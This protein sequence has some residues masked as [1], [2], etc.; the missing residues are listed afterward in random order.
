M[1]FKSK[2]PPLRA[3]PRWHGI[4]GPISMDLP[5]EA[6]LILTNKLKEALKPCGVFEDSIELQHREKVVKQLESLYK[7]WLTETSAQMDLPESVIEN[8]GGKIYPFGSYRLGVHSKGADIDALCIGP[9]FL[10][11]KVFFTSFFDKLKAQKEVKNI[12]TIK[13]AY[14]PV[15]KMTYN[16]IEIDLLFAR[17]PRKSI[18][19][20]LNLLNNQWLNGLDIHC[21]RSL[22][23]YRVSE[24][25]LKSVPKVGNFRLALRA[26][27]LWAKRRNIYSNAMG[28]LGGVSWAI[29]VARICQCYPNATSS[30]LVNKFFK[31]YN[32]WEW[33]IPIL[34]RRIEDC[35]YSLPV[36]APFAKA[37]HL[38]PIIT[39]AYPA[40]NTTF[41]VSPSSVAIITE[42]IKRGYA[43]TEDIQQR[44]ADWSNLFEPS[45][46]FDQY[47]HYLLLEATSTTEEQHLE[48]VGLVESKMRL[49]VGNLEKNK[50]VSL[51]HIGLQ[52]FPGSNNGNTK[53]GRSTKWLIG[54]EYKGSESLNVDLNPAFQSFRDTLY[55]C[56]LYQEGMTISA[57]Y[58]AGSNSETPNGDGEPTRVCT[59][60]PRPTVSHQVSATAPA[61][62]TAPVSAGRPAIKR[63]GWSD[64]K[65][66]AKRVKADK[67]SVSVANGSTASTPSKPASNSMSPWTGKRP[68]APQLATS[69]LK[70]KS[71]EEPTKGPKTSN[72]SLN[73]SR[74]QSKSSK[75]SKKLRTLELETRKKATLDL[76]PPAV[77]LTEDMTPGPTQPSTCVKRSIKLH[78][79]RRK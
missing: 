45:N 41:N 59:P 69:T 51:A 56:K 32:M 54:L 18:A 70:I 4:T 19:G 79:I 66:N 1:S 68:C 36:W 20:K 47:K 40:Q 60:K 6:D 11:R 2:A 7:E 24:E 49:L 34:L 14:V 42:E 29:L 15:I 28:F 46:F 31:V 76:G 12:R 65:T 72:I 74:S 10:E 35:Y 58:V 53:E 43:I 55:N 27:K 39:P 50:H 77:E 44:K 3:A 61:G 57:T 37:C 22:N 21:V 62:H 71:N 78:L 63:K 25:I 5:K 9:S 16:G 23:G 17:L 48:W 33:P 38:M 52:P 75:S 13:D 8:V 67:E 73:K 30:T 64:S 26:I